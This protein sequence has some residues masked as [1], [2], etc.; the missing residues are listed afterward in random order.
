MN[1]VITIN[2]YGLMTTTLKLMVTQIIIMRLTVITPG[3]HYFWHGL[4]S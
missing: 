2:V 4:L 3:K 1:A